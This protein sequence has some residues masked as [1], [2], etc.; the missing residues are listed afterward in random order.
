MFTQQKALEQCHPVP[1][2]HEKWTLAATL[3]HY[4][5][6]LVPEGEVGAVLGHRSATSVK[7]TKGYI[8]IIY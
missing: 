3:V 2:S 4:S 6:H 1:Q 8:S 7:Q 5:P